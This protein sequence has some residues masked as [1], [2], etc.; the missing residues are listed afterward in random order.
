VAPLLEIEDLPTH[1]K[2]R[3][4]RSRRYTPPPGAARTIA[5]IV[6]LRDQVLIPCLAGVRACALAP[7]PGNPA[8]ADQHCQKLRSRRREL[9]HDGG[10]TAA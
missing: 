3:Q 4:G 10:L 6:I 8:T 5:A 2:L 1:I 9:L 7:L